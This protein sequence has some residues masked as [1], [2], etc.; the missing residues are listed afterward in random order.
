[1][2]HPR[3][4]LLFGARGQVGREL[5]RVLGPLGE[6]V[7]ADREHADLTDSDAVRALIRNTQPSLLVNAAA[8][9]AV[10]KAEEE[11]ELARMVNAVAP[12]I[13]AEE[14]AA[15][16]A[17][18]VH[19]STDYV[20]DGTANRP[21]TED[22][23]TKPVNTYGRTKLAGEEAIRERH[24]AHLILRTSWVYGLRR[25]N[26]LRTMLRLAKTHP[27]LRVVDDQIG[28]PTWCRTIAETTAVVL[29]RWLTDDEPSAR[30][31]T[32]H[33]TCAG[34]TSWC[35][36]ARAIF[37][38]FIDQPDDRPD[39]EPIPSSEYPTSAQ[40]PPF[41]VLDCRRLRDVFAVRLPEW[42]S[43]LQMVAQDASDCRAYRRSAVSTE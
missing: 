23:A 39:V 19:Y 13:L 28:A 5:Q 7:A 34:Q 30:A 1:M 17:P 12:G 22:D 43:A 32:Y 2:T 10:D 21:Y 6:V 37:E 26:F 40:R 9:T 8:Y 35:G 31:G 36:F 11:T 42:S 29:A 18:L 41:S 24:A 3:H 33:L 4:I 25:Q 16:G 27:E 15:L 14:A 38:A 20:F